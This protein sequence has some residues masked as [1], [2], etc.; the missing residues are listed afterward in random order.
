V[1]GTPGPGTITT[2]GQIDTNDDF[3]AVAIGAGLELNVDCYAGSANLFVEAISTSGVF[4]G[5][6]TS[7]NGSTLT[8]VQND[9]NL[10][11]YGTGTADIDGVAR[12]RSRD[13]VGIRARRREHHL[14]YRVQLPC[15]RDP[16]DLARRPVI[17]AIS[18]AA[19]RVRAALARSDRLV[20][21]D[22]QPD[23]ARISSHTLGPRDAAGWMLK[24]LAGLLDPR[25]GG[26]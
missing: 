1:P 17:R 15:A 7:W 4:Y 3:H 12:G 14:G 23:L 25:P 18:G 9:G 8:S 10:H 24:R 22:R 19:V 5:W 2:D 26:E 21:R 13:I 16:T 6:G 20:F 11:V